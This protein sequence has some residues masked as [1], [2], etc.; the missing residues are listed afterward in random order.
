MR[1]TKVFTAIAL[2]GLLFSC[3]ASAA[4]FGPVENFDVVND[5]G[6]EAHG[7][8][9][10]LEKFVNKVNDI[11][12]FE[13]KAEDFESEVIILKN[14]VSNLENNNWIATGIKKLKKKFKK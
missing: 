1:K 9:I 14:E 7:F 5:T 13:K 8:E 10:E 3:T 12:K 4:T 6:L 11:E 2:A